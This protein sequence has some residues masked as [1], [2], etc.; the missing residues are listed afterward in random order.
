MEIRQIQYFLSIVETGSFSE[1]AAVQNI[2]QSSLSK[3]II[4]LEKELNTTLF[5]RSGRNVTLT[6]SG[7]AFKGHAEAMIETFHTMVD[8]LGAYKN[9][10]E[11]LRVGT[12]PVLTQYGITNII[13]GFRNQ[14]PAIRL[15]M[16]ELD[17]L[18]IIPALDKHRFDLAIT[19]RNYID[20]EE[21]SIVN[22]H[23]DKLLVAVSTKCR[24]VNRSS[25]S[26]QELK[27][28]NF[29]VFDNVTELHK[30]VLDECSKAG[31]DP[32]IFYS[33]HQKT[34]VFGL[35]GANIGLALIPAKI[36]EYHKQ[37]EVV[38]IPLVEDIECDI[39]LVYPKRR[40]LPGA[41][42]IFLGYIQEAL[43]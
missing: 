20:Q 11:P 7:K 29:I 19:R 23:R 32:T 5:D 36:Y 41:A 14:Y 16:E 2:S 28:D 40:K 4:A 17:G 9:E 8:D 25:I 42:Q 13:A 35:V 31:F 10:A 39:V 27:E 33:S 34:S 21:Y 6:D 30:L 3:R 24:H 18:N 37:P 26:L 12:I 15:L 43:R 1:A 22:L 38:A